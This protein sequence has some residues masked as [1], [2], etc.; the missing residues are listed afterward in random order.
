[1][2]VRCTSMGKLRWRLGILCIT[3]LS[4]AHSHTSDA[5]PAPMPALTTADRIAAAIARP[6]DSFALDDQPREI[7]EHGKFRCPEVEIVH[8]RGTTLPYQSPVQLQRDF[9]AR[10]AAFELVVVDVARRVYGR[11]PRRIRH[12]GGYVCRRMKTF[13]TFISEHSFGDAIDIEGFDFGDATRAERTAAPRGLRGSFSVRVQ[14]D[15]HATSGTSAIHARFLH[16]LAEALIAR[17]D[18]FRVILGPGYPD[19]DD[20]LHLDMSP[21]RTV[22]LDLP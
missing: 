7:P 19:H 6:I 13:P 14:K 4:V 11:A 8:Y 3:F 17:D 9:V 15:W 16:E 21:F 1:M 2:V 12:L 18:L 20:H 5:E 22:E 10:V